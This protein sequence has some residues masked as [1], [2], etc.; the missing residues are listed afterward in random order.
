MMLYWDLLV[1]ADCH[2]SFRC[3]CRQ[4]YNSPSAIL[5]GFIFRIQ[6]PTAAASN[7][8]FTVSFLPLVHVRY[9]VRGAPILS[10]R[11]RECRGGT[12]RQIGASLGET[13]PSRLVQLRAR[14][15]PP[16]QPLPRAWA[17]SGQ[18]PAAPA[19]AAAPGASMANGVATVLAKLESRRYR[20][21]E[22]FGK[23][24]KIEH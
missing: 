19:A 8:V 13:C 22:I 3:L 10:T 6:D 4:F 21:K 11:A 24:C 7:S 18:Q 16:G 23:E 17:I 5:A 15:R 12:V 14:C 2:S 1:R 20:R 9:H